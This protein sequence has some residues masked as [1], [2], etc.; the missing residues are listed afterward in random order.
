[1]K[2]VMF[3]HS[4][5]SDWNHG[6]AHFIRGIVK[7]LAKRGHEVETYEAED[8]WSLTNMVKDHGRGKMEEFKWYYR[9]LDPQFYPSGRNFIK[10]AIL[11]DADL[12]IVH[13][14]NPPELV[15]KIGQEKEKYGF[16]LLFHD[17]HHRSV[18]DEEAMQ[19][20]NLDNYDGA[21]VF[22]EAIKKI[23]EDRQWVKNVW[24]WHEAAD[25]EL[26]KPNRDETK[27]GDL[28]WIGNWGDGERTLELM[29]FL[30]QPI[31]DL[32]IKAKVYGV[33]YPEEA[34]KILREANIEY[35]GWLPNYRVPEVFA[36]YKVTVHVPRRPYVEKLPGIPTIRPF[37]ALSCGIPLICSPWN[38]AE[39]LFTQGKDYLMAKD[40]NS[41]GYMIAEVL[42]SPQLSQSLSQNGRKTILA[43]HT[44]A[45]RVDEL[46]EIINKI[47]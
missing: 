37:E 25:A 3:Y 38:D 29:E 39:H 7:E 10:D 12:V 14:W 9:S 4:F 47:N 8:N 13:E 2:I 34:Q 21:L 5:Y 41:M 28:V 40:G 1:M 19:R 20:Y 30:V 42:K 36:K 15:A 33:R 45:H 32:G 24:T 43:K 16:K 31:K 6:N 44:C 11:R 35:G 22:G 26:F 23:Y 46:E 17:T 27:E 18:T